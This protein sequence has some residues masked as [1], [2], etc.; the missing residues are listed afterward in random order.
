MI[1]LDDQLLSELGLPNLPREHRDMLHEAVRQELQIRVGAVIAEQLTRRQLDDLESCVK[2]RDEAG[3]LAWLE[4]NSPRYRDI[5][6]A[7][8]E[9]LGTE[10]ASLRAEIA[11]L[12]VLYQARLTSQDDLASQ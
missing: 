6:A 4:Q 9:K 8:L 7:Q 5:V 11:T 12:S 1:K 10:I 2:S 3:A